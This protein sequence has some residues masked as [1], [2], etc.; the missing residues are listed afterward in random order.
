M[1][2]RFAAHDTAGRDCASV[3][4]AP[5]PP[6]ALRRFL[7]LL[8][9]A[10]DLVV[11]ILARRWCG[12]IA[13]NRLR[14]RLV[15]ADGLVDHEPEPREGLVDLSAL[16]SALQE[17]AEIRDVGG[18]RGP[19]LPR[20]QLRV[21][22]RLEWRFGF[23]EGRLLLEYELVLE[24]RLFLARRLLVE[25]EPQRHRYAW[26]RLHV[27]EGRVRKDP[28]L[29]DCLHVEAAVRRHR[30]DARGEA[31]RPLQL[32]LER[33]NPAIESRRPRAIG[34]RLFLERH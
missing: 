14:R 27:R 26:R 15:Q 10:T 4:R 20:R 21:E 9:H 33:R 19:G 32:A 25:Y 31:A 18:R 16:D 24:F 2:P 17:T 30:S 29:D 8:P 6:A 11:E 12:D 1:P 3:A 28:P 22:R 7:Q 13:E 23:F 34:D 5:A